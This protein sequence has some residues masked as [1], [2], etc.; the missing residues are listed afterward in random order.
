MHINITSQGGQV[1]VTQR[2]GQKPIDLKFDVDGIQNWYPFNH[3][4]TYCINP[5]K[6]IELVRLAVHNVPD[7]PGAVSHTRFLNT[8]LWYNKFVYEDNE[9]V[10]DFAGAM[11]IASPFT[12]YTTADVSEGFQV[13]GDTI[14]QMTVK[15]TGQ[16][17]EEQ[18]KRFSQHLE[19]EALHH[20]SPDQERMYAHFGEVYTMLNMMRK[21]TTTNGIGRPARPDSWSFIKG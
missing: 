7:I 12:K 14:D 3:G 4:Y 10:A 15:A 17:L 6:E 20:L 11:G 21:V 16:Y 19:G 1:T 13:L 2:N 8:F 5:N 9:R 18:G